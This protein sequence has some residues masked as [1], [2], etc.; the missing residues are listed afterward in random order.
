MKITKETIEDDVL[1]S[2]EITIF[3]DSWNFDTPARAN[4]LYLEG[5]LPESTYYNYVIT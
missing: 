2:S 3:K 4:V 5:Y 1:A